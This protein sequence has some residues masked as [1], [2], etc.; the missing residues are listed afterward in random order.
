M[1]FDPYILFFSLQLHVS[2]LYRPALTPVCRACGQHENSY[3]NLMILRN[4]TSDSSLE[5]VCTLLGQAEYMFASSML[6]TLYI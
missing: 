4:S 2:F 5:L 3:F 1:E 6:R